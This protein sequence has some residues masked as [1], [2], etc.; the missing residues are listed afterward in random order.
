MPE[1]LRLGMVGGGPG[2]FI[3]PIHRLAAE[4]DRRFRLVAGAFSSDPERSRAAGEA[5]GLDPSRVHDAWQEFLADEARRS[6]DERVHAVAVVTPNHLHAGPAVAFLEAGVA[7]A[8]DK[9]LADSVESARAVAEAAS[10]SGRPCLVTF[11]YAGYP[12][13]EEMRARVAAGGIGELRRVDVEY[14]QGWL[15]EPIERD[16]QKQAAWRTDPAQAGA[17]GALGDIGSHAFHLVEHVS[18]RRVAAVTGRARSAVAGRSLDDDAAFVLE[19]EGDVL[20]S[21][22]VSQVCAGRENGLRLQVAGSRATL[23][24]EQER[25]NHLHV[26]H[27]DGRRE[28]V[29]PGHPRLAPSAR[30][31]CRTPPGHPEGWLEAF[32]NLYAAFADALE[33]RDG[34]RPSFPD[35][36]IGLR[37]QELV[38]SALDASRSGGRVAT[39]A[40]AS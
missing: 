26:F 1:P 34:G 39:V 24:W 11:T 3:G 7:L 2:A 31:L 30:A 14:F 29:R 6:E 17:A 12:L 23:L 38:T 20:G 37:V 9:P 22:C 5:W 16:G 8:C 19:L 36:A 40:A 28:V 25:P 27:A 18:G 10:A 21:L 35:A 4:M 33:G 32:A 13:V 15:A